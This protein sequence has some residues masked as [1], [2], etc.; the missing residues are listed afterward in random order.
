MRS[1]VRSVVRSRRSP[2]AG[3]GVQEVP[4][5]GIVHRAEV[6]ALGAA[7]VAPLALG[8]PLPT[9]HHVAP[10]TVQYLVGIRVLHH[11][12]SR[13][14]LLLHGGVVLDAVEVAGG[15][16]CVAGAGDGPARGA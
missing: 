15:L 11:V 12:Y 13:V 1:V 6:G 10:A 2:V 8:G 16:V 7:D 5:A 14:L 3:E 4:R 9:R